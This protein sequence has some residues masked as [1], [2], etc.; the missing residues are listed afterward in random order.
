MC[1][2]K[3]KTN[4]WLGAALFGGECH[5]A[6]SAQHGSRR[7]QRH[8]AIRAEHAGVALHL[9]G[10]GRHRRSVRRLDGHPCFQHERSSAMQTRFGPTKRWASMVTPG[11]RR[12]P[13]AVS[14]IIDSA[15]YP[16]FMTEFGAAPGVTASAAWMPN[17]VGIG[18]SWRLLADLPVY[19]AHRRFNRCDAAKNLFKHRR[20]RRSRAGRPDY[21]NFPSPRGHVCQQRRSLDNSGKLR[22]QLLDWHTTAPSRRRILTRA[23]KALPITN[24]PRPISAANIAPTRR[25]TLKPRRTPAAATMSPARRRVNGWNTPSGFKCRDITISRFAMPLPPMVAPCK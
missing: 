3:S 9:C 18:T 5:A 19:P 25:W 11:A 20:Q 12:H 6:R 2:L 14:Q 23:E 22:Q 8:P 21:G 4:R 24:S 10:V 16:C 13:T 17:S 15:G 1:C 7:L